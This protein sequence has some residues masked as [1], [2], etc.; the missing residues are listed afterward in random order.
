MVQ[1]HA[2]EDRKDTDLNPDSGSHLYG[3]QEA[4]QFIRNLRC[5]SNSSA[6][7]YYLA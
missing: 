4:G 3:L 6:M 7:G 5:K 2:E 1:G